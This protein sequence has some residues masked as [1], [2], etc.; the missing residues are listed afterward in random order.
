MP[1]T[2]KKP[3]GAKDSKDAKGG[4]VKATLMRKVGPLPVVAWVG[5]ASVGL[6]ILMRMRRGSSAADGGDPG[7]YYV[8]NPASAENPP[9]DQPTD[10]G[11]ASASSSDLLPVLSAI[12]DLAASIR[13]GF[14]SQNVNGA[15]QQTATAAGAAP[16]GAKVQ[17]GQ[18][19]VSV[20]GTNVSVLDIASGK[21]D[22]LLPRAGDLAVEP[23]GGWTVPPLFQQVSPNVVIDSTGNKQP[24]VVGMVNPNNRLVGYADDLGNILPDFKPGRTAIWR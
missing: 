15:G 22:R 20:G 2:D 6:F 7:S 3:G 21:V 14:G 23:K 18:S 5:L 12:A 19:T 8:T 9:A 1:D 16:V 11:G 13:A 24:G 17:S 10:S 4:G